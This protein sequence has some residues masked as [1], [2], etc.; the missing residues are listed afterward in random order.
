MNMFQVEI[1]IAEDGALSERMEKMRTWLDQSRCEPAT[2]RFSFANPGII[3]RVDFPIET[4]AAAF[5]TAFEGKLT[6][7]SQMA[8]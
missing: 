1:R 4:E 7:G 2:F 6:S 5:A 8:T 3:C